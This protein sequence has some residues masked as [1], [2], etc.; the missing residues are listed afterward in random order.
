MNPIPLD[1]TRPHAYPQRILIATVGGS[2]AVLTETLYVL[3][4]VQNPAFVPTEVHLLTTTLGAEKAAACLLGENG[5]GQFH[6]FLH[7]YGLTGRIHFGAECIH[8][9][10][11]SA[12]IALEDIRSVADN[13]AAADFIT[14]FIRRKAEGDKQCALHVSLTGGRKTLGHYLAAA[15]SLH[16]RP[17]DRLS[18]TLVSEPYETSVPDFYYPHPHDVWLERRG[19]NSKVL[20]REATLTMAEIPF[21]RLREGRAS[22]EFYGGGSFS[23]VVRHAQRSIGPVRLH[24]DLRARQLVF[25]DTVA[26]KLSPKLFAFYCWLARRRH[27]HGAHVWVHPAHDTPLGYLREYA[28]LRDGFATEALEGKYAWA[29]QGSEPTPDQQENWKN[30]FEQAVSKIKRQFIDQLGDAAT[31]YLVTRGGAP[32]SGY[33]LALEPD[34][35]RLS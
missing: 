29:L 23:E 21:V 9:L 26:Q 17:Q 22:R 2:P 16:G 35:I 8:V 10:R 30:D 6:A 3:T 19:A 13:E 14:E 33:G 28:R 20:S 1:S 34:Q 5:S 15:L 27:E 24:V 25:G 32:I 18:H 7:D 4:Q 12:G 31:P 11:N